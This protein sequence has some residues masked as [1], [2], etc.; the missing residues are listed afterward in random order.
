MW[1]AGLLFGINTQHRPRH[2]RQHSGPHILIIVT[3][4]QTS[5]CIYQSIHTSSASK[6]EGWGGEVNYPHR[7]LCISYYSQSISSRMDSVPA[8][9]ST[10]GVVTLNGRK[11]YMCSSVFGDVRNTENNRLKCLLWIT[12]KELLVIETWGTSG[13]DRQRKREREKGRR[14][15]I[16]R[17]ERKRAQ[18]Q[19]ICLSSSE[20][21][22]SAAQKSSLDR[23]YNSLSQT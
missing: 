20:K 22:K 3:L 8:S 17:K 15:P 10:T 6:P 23:K 21:R 16:R 9:W 11:R 13:M 18:C 4:M 1:E 19:N 14:R 12:T 7:F 2:S 5:P